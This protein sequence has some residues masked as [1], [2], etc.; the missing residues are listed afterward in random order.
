MIVPQLLQGGASDWPIAAGGSTWLPPRTAPP[1]V[2]GTTRSL[3]VGAA[4]P[5]SSWASSTTDSPVGKFRP[6]QR[7]T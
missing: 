1:W 4:S 2:I 6:S 3:P 7:N 5:Y